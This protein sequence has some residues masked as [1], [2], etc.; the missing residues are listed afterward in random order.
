MKR[1]CAIIGMSGFVMFSLVSFS[2]SEDITIT[3]YYPSPFGSY[4]EL[5]TTNNTYL[6]TNSATSV[7]IG[8]T[9]P[10][11]G[12]KLDV[13]DANAVIVRVR[14]NAAQPVL[15]LDTGSGAAIPT[16]QYYRSGAQQ[17]SLELNAANG[18][19][20]TMGATPAIVI[21][22]TGAASINGNVSITGSLTSGSAT[23]TGNLSVS[24]STTVGAATINGNALVNGS[25]TATG[26]KSAA[27][28]TSKG[29]RKLYTVEAADCR[30][31][32]FGSAKLIDGQAE[33]KL[34]PLFLETVT[35]SNK[36]PMVVTLTLTSDSPGLYVEKKT[37]NSF[38]VREVQAGKGSPTFDYRVTAMRK[39][40]ENSRLELVENEKAKHP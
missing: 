3:T 12:T 33:V 26:G 16:I 30:F 10:A 29:L 6:A 22:Q 19:Q 2:F 20:V 4:R 1:L 24:G 9:T 40:F 18:F 14:S 37:L 25:M 39:G 15:R 28:M 32:D 38:V 36:Y 7:G 13:V 23:H 21:S 34:D 27:V 35:I 31:E 11:P 5:T 8:T 17:V